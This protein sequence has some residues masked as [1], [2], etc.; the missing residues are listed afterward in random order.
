MQ[1]SPSKNF[2]AKLIRLGQVWLDFGK[3]WA[4]LNRNFFAKVMRFGQIL[5][6][7]GKIWAKSKSYISKYIR[8]P[9]S[10]KKAKCKA[11]QNLI[12]TSKH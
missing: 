9:T 8:S 3:I 7:F 10:M 1:P 11:E 12:K 4:K 6:D 5:E 2:L